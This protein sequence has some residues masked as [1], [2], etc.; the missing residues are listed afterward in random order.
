MR[1]G[2]LL[3]YHKIGGGRREAATGA[4]A[5]CGCWRCDSYASPAAALISHDLILSEGFKKT[6]QGLGLFV[7]KFDCDWGQ[8]TLDSGPKNHLRVPTRVVD[9]DAFNSR[10]DVGLSSID[11]DC[12]RYLLLLI[13]QGGGKR[14]R[15]MLASAAGFGLVVEMRP[16]SRRP[17]GRQGHNGRH[18]ADMAPDREAAK[19]Y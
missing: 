12:H 1:R 8:L 3:L 2:D 6:R 18:A 4:H 14:S 9:I 16:A 11:F 5:Y 15:I 10:E 17:Y 7:A 13:D 19:R